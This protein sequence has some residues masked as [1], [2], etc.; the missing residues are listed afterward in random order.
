MSV[1]SQL[2]LNWDNLQRID[3][4]GDRYIIVDSIQDLRAEDSFIKPKNKL[5]RF[6]GSGE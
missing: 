2:N 5:A 6:R 3:I 4:S 1:A